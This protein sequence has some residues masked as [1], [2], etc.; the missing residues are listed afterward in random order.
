MV[1]QLFHRGEK[2][3]SQEGLELTYS[4]LSTILN[5]A[6][7]KTP[8]ERLSVFNGFLNPNERDIFS[9]KI[10]DYSLKEKRS[11]IFPSGAENNVLPQLLAL[12]DLPKKLADKILSFCQLNLIS[13]ADVDR[14]NNREWNSFSIPV[15]M[16]WMTMGRR[17]R[18]KAESLLGNEGLII[19]FSYKKS[20]DFYLREIEK[21]DGGL[22]FGEKIIRVLADKT[23]GEINEKSHQF[24]SVRVVSK[25]N[26]NKRDVCHLEDII[27]RRLD[28]NFE[29]DYA[30][31]ILNKDLIS[32]HMDDIGKVLGI[33]GLMAGFFYFVDQ[34][35]KG[36]IT[37]EMY[38]GFQALVK[39]IT[40]LWANL[41][42]F[43]SQYKLFLKGDTFK[44]QI[45]DLIKNKF[46]WR[47]GFI[48]ANGSFID[49]LSEVVGNIDKFFGS[50]VFGS[51][52]M[53]GTLLTSYSGS[54]RVSQRNKSFF[55]RL[56]ILL[57]NPAVLSMNSAAFLTLLTSIGLLGFAH[58]FHNPFWVVVV[59]GMSEPIYALMAN[60]FFTWLKIS[61]LKQEIFIKKTTDKKD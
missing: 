28:K 1:E 21:I 51:E 43:Y 7:D 42:D 13:K 39:V 3:K 34:I 9:E 53:I 27:N 41:V 23:N 46:G 31:L 37:Q 59:G 56:R 4:Q 45:V 10:D 12:L 52:P 58:Q 40:H 32:E 18:R 54:H 22:S 5:F 24:I 57:E 30:N 50:V 26:K 47:E 60:K 36:K 33:T 49:V 48:L 29:K 6:S 35:V 17:L 2:Y 8:K 16:S 19:V 38:L 20:P 15:V 25:E 14:L 44:D 55:E 61:R 11:I